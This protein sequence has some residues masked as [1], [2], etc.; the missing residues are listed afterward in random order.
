MKLNSPVE[1]TPSSPRPLRSVSER[2]S[3][4][5][6]ADAQATPRA[7][8][9]LWEHAQGLPDGQRPTERCPSAAPTTSRAGAVVKPRQLNSHRLHASQAAIGLAATA[10]SV[11]T[12][13]TATVGL[14][15]GMPL[16]GCLAGAAMW[17]ALVKTKDALLGMRSDGKLVENATVMRRFM[18]YVMATRE[19]ARIDYQQRLR[20][21]PAHAF[22]DD[23]NSRHGADLQ[24]TTFHVILAAIQRANLL[25]PGLNRFV[26]GKR[27]FERYGYSVAFAVKS[28]KKAFGAL[29]TVKLEAI[30]GEDF[31]GYV[32]R[33]NQSIHAERTVRRANA[34][35]SEMKLVERLPRPLLSLAMWGR[36]ILDS[37]GLWPKSWID[38]D[39][40]YASVFIANLGSLDK[41]EMPN[42]KHHLY[43]CGTVSLFGTL[44]S[45]DE[46]GPSPTMLVNWTYDE[47]VND[48]HY[49]LAPLKAMRQA[50]EEP[51]LL[52][53]QVSIERVAAGHADDKAAADDAFVREN[54]MDA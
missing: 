49:C 53:E 33:I 2:S 35:E 48:G 5:P 16:G 28:V 26:V 11:G 4:Q 24:I 54:T 1:A 17:Y 47:R 19:S 41:D 36:D 51:Y 50:V 6:F 21:D 25:H 29:R 7:S 39:P 20:L 27:L 9:D 45:I 22:V 12:Y 13:L 43:E 18:P 38:P 32:R 15:A 52:L 3:F 42:V 40:L 30:E 8:T 46:T 31:A 14:G 23:W 10:A 37:E 34:T 44:C